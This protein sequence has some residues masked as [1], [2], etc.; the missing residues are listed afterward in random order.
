MLRLGIYLQEVQ[1]Y[2]FAQ[3][4]TRMFRVASFENAGLLETT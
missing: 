2:A 4:G 3:T 1:T